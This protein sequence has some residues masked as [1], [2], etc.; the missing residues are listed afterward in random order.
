MASGGSDVGVTSEAARGG[1]GV[2][3]HGEKGWWVTGSGAVGV[4]AQGDV[5]DAV[6][7]SDRP[8]SAG[9][10]RRE[11]RGRPGRRAGW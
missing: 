10:G 2:A 11:W 4:F 6:Q 9:Q 8:V 5:V 3:D 7:G 1:D